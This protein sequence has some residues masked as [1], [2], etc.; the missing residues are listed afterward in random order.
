MTKARYE[1][2]QLQQM[3]LMEYEDQAEDVDW[4]PIRIHFGIT[5]FGANGFSGR[6]GS[7]VIIE[8]SETEESGTRHEELYF[9][10]AGRATFTVEGE[11]VDAP[12][13]AL[14]YVPD[15]TAMRGAVAEEDG[16]SIICF[17]G[18]PGEAFEISPWEK[19]YD[20]AAAS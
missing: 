14:V 18:T 1:A 8:H 11:Q 10:A 3:P 7:Q 9:V 12:A 20:P 16:T 17:G 2:I 5:S 13:G 19:A 15:P 4:Q 6:K